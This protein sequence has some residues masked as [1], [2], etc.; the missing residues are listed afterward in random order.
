MVKQTPWSKYTPEEQIKLNK[1]LRKF[2]DGL[3]YDTSPRIG[4][5]KRRNPRTNKVHQLFHHQPIAANRLVKRDRD[6]PWATRNASML[7]IHEV[8]TGKTITAIL[9]AAAAYAMPPDREHKPR[10]TE[11]ILIVCPKSML[12]VWYETLLEWTELGPDTILCVPEQAKVGHVQVRGATIIL[13]TPDVLTTAWKTFMYL[14]TGEAERGKK[15]ESRWVPG[16]DPKN[17][18][19]LAELGGMEPPVHPLF[20]PLVEAKEGVPPFLLTVVDEVHMIGD[21]TKQKGHVIRKFT[22]NSVYKLGLTGTP[23]KRGPDEISNL[24][25]LLAE[26]SNDG[27][28]SER[29][30]FQER[31]HF[32]DLSGNIK[33]NEVNAWHVQFV[34]RVDKKHIEL[35]P[36]HETYLLYD[37]FVGLADDGRQDEG[38]IQRH[39]EVLQRAKGIWIEQGETAPIL[40]EANSAEEDADAALPD[41]P[42]SGRWGA[43]QRD[44]FAAMIKMGHYEFHSLLGDK[45]AQA[46]EQD[47]ALY[48]QATARPSQ[49]MLLIE[50]VIKIQ[51]ASGHVRI[52]VFAELSTQL[53]LLRRHL[54]AKPEFGD[55]FMFTGELNEK[56]RA[57]MV[58]DFLSCAKGVIFLTKAGGIGINLQHGCEVLLSVGSLPWN[59]TDIQQA[60]GRVHRINQQHPVKFIQLVARRS[61]TAAKLELHEDK[62]LRLA[63]VAKN[64]N[65]ANFA[66]NSTAWKWTTKML[67]Y[68][69]DLDAAGN[70]KVTN[71]YL[72]DLQEYKRKRALGEDVNDIRSVRPVLPS[73]VAL[74]SFVA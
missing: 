63:E 41:N 10:P 71:K 48:Q 20:A 2:T 21:R 54:E 70:Y 65:Y 6:K 66:N 13:T 36:L 22:T 30:R 16:V 15:K 29:L 23:V 18:K 31:T 59:A 27:K 55:L 25:R 3:F 7:A 61:I 12:M 40:D 51:Q 39:N 24:A 9:A 44:T 28:G 1:H 58:K 73:R 47:D 68:V 53:E 46:F 11:K 74:P 35:P 42:E 62:D 4:I 52:A 50:R 26:V 49:A 60:V 67:D 17:T 14:K 43:P 19:R 37:P 72:D 57:V 38:A 69:T 64:L 8:G 5:L 33:D 45:G 34:D 56:Q 32:T